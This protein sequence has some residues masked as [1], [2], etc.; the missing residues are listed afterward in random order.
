MFK[1]IG[2][3]FE[4]D[5]IDPSFNNGISPNEQGKL[6]S[7]GRGALFFILQS[8]KINHPNINGVLIPDY[9]CDSVVETLNTAKIK[10][11]VYHLNSNL[12]IDGSGFSAK[13]LASYAVI[14]VNY[15]GLSSLKEEINKIREVYS[16]SVI[17][18]D[19]VQSF[20]SMFNESD[21]D[22]RFTSFRKSI[23]LPDGG[24]ALSRYPLLSA[25]I[26]KN[27]FAQYKIAGS[28]LKA[29]R[30]LNYY[31]DSIYLNLF[32]QGEVI[33][34]DNITKSISDFSLQSFSHIDYNLYGNIRKKNA[35]FLFKELIKNDI[36]P[37]MPLGEN[38]PLFVP[39]RLKRR[40]KVR[41]ALMSENIFCPIH[42][43]FTDAF[44]SE[45]RLG[46]IMNEEELSL[47]VDYRY[48]SDDMQRIVNIVKNNA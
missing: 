42:W 31:D 9:I 23:P 5:I 25:D 43:P 39:I 21:A 45:F 35:D 1:V 44:T 30:S 11:E 17:I 19:D 4:T 15:F 2:G 48:D 3:E 47:V 46:K 36:N 41:H 8:I 18:E 6:Y 34:N 33:I 22:Y 24:W 20:Y 13:K 27:T 7:S 38:V 28:I 10:W 37:I 16:N 29:K 32:E 12:S 26:D 14:I 40:D